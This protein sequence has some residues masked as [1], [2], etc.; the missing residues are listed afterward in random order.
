MRDTV[1]GCV[2]VVKDA[3]QAQKREKQVCDTG[4]WTFSIWHKIPLYSLPHPHFF[5]SSV[6]L[7]VMESVTPVR[8]RKFQSL[9]YCEVPCLNSH[10]PCF[11]NCS[12]PVLSVRGAELDQQRRHLQGHLPIRY[13][14]IC[15]Q[16]S[17]NTLKCHL[18]RHEQSRLSYINLQRHVKGE[19]PIMID[20][21]WLHT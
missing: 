3:E 14:V 1:K 7:S 16:Q 4:N 5:F 19:L 6:H 12:V 11:L 9:Q 8:I 10:Q 15:G 13:N 18:Q 21:D 17:C 2:T 20:T